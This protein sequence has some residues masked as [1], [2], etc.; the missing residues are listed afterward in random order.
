MKITFVGHASLLIEAAGIRILSD[1]WW[2]GPCFGAQWWTYPAP[3]AEVIANGV[4]YVYVSHGHHDHLHPGTLQTLDRRAT[5]LVARSIGLGDSLR[6]L[7]F[8][9]VELGDDDVHEIAPGVSCRILET[10]ADDTLLV[11][12]DDERVCINLN[13]AL[14]AAPASVQDAF[15]AKLKSLY[16]RIDYVFCGYGTA[17]HFPNCY[18]IPGKDRAASAARRQ[19]YFNRQWVRLVAGLA[20]RF[21][22]PFAADVV[23]LEEDLI[24]ANEPTHNAERPTAVFRSAVRGAATQVFD[25]APGFAIEGDQVLVESLRKPLS[26]EQLRAQCQEGIAR[27]NAYGAGSQKVFDETLELLTANVGRCLPYLR[28]YDGDYRFLLRFRNFPTGIE[29]V[30]RSVSVTVSPAPFPVDAHYDL[31]YLTRLNYVRNALTSPFGHEILFVGS[32][33]IFRYLRASDAR[34]NLHRELITVLVPRAESPPSR[35]GDN[36]PTLYRLKR[37]VKRWLGRSTPDLYDLSAWTDWRNPE[38]SE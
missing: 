4:D 26:E 29:I 12:E 31:A 3:H 19:A 36:S 8:P 33:G 15:I 17:S 6:E 28:E 14:H 24:W 38:P 7:G 16:P 13:D 5:C 37:R 32:G 22:F 35:F 30:K 10:H 2:R 1:P 23:F 21:A 25:I 11:V 27:S 20:P 9:V 34:N 18:D